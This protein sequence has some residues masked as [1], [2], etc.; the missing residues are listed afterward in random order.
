M[1]KVGPQK[2]LQCPT[3]LRNVLI[4]V[5]GASTFPPN[6]Y[7]GFEAEVAGYMSEFASSSGVSVY[8]NAMIL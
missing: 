5:G 6:L 2:S 7:L 3:C 1:E 4:P 8:K